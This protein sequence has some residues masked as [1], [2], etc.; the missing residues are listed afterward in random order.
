MD[1]AGNEQFV[2]GGEPFSHREDEHEHQHH[3]R[4]DEEDE[5]HEHHHNSQPLSGDG[6]SPGK[7]FI[8]GLARDTTVVVFV[9]GFAA[10]FVKHFG[11]Y[12]EITD[13]VI[14]K[15]RKTGQPRGFGFITYAD[16]SVVDKVIED[17]HVINGKQMSLETF[18]RAMEKSRIT[19]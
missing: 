7:I 14:M 13:S 17:N 6:A 16:P 3:R 2:G 1:S 9:Y 10:Q 8:G 15:D 5:E 19:K 4:E 12:G 11:K 18:L